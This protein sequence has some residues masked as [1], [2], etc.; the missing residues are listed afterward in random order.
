[1]FIPLC[2]DAKLLEI[3]SNSGNY[4]ISA[5]KTLR[6]CQTLIKAAEGLRVKVIIISDRKSIKNTKLPKNVKVLI[7]LPYWRYI[8]LMARSMFVVIPL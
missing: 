2:V 7:D 1:M 3:N 4:I 8:Q 6:D 5:G